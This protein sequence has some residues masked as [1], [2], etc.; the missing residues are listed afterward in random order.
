[1]DAIPIMFHFVIIQH[2]I[3]SNDQ[4]HDIEPGSQVC[5][6]L[7]KKFDFISFEAINLNKKLVINKNW[8]SKCIKAIKF[9][10]HTN[11]L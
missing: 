4:G 8:L 3:L 11:I 9:G 6:R 7:N 10:L 2:I 5:C 1:M